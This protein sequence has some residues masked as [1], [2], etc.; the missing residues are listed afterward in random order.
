MMSALLTWL[1]GRLPLTRRMRT[2]AIWL[3]SPKF[4]VGVVGLVRDEE[5]RVLMLKHTYR[6]HYP[7]GLPGGGLVPGETLEECLLR[8]VREE[9]G[10]E[11]EIEA[12]LSAAAHPDRRL[13]SAIF[14]CKPVPGASLDHFRPN[15]EIE[16]AHFFPVDEL[17]AET[18]MGVR[19]LIDVALRQA[20]GE[21]FTY[22]PDR[23][24]WP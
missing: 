5:G 20:E 10:L 17:P 14:S 1:Y 2:A 7:W 16:E 8:E 23:G 3:L 13:V 15:S 11:V 22:R 21:P 9:T 4:V 18:S 24:Q 6:R 12:M 19:R